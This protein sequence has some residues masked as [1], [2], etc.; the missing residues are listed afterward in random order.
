M[1]DTQYIFPSGISWVTGLTNSYQ[2]LLLG[3]KKYKITHIVFS[4]GAA[5]KFVDIAKIGTPSTIFRV[6]VP[7][8]DTVVLP[9]WDT[10][11]GGIRVRTTSA[12]GDLDVTA[13]YVLVGG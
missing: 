1:I 10:D 4:G 5:A 6:G 7:A 11:T 3:G 2:T 12:A 8:N 9:G 13:F